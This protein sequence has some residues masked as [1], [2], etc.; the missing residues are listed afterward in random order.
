MV[1]NNKTPANSVKELIDCA[2]ARPGQLTFGST[3][4]GALDYLAVELFMRATGTRLVH[5]P[6]RGGAGRAQRSHGRLDRPAHR[7]V[8]RGHGADQ[9]RH[10]TAEVKR[11]VAFMIEAGMRK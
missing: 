3:G 5:V 10:H 11:W 2:K 8:S 1:V 7:G 6:Y 9:G 4:T